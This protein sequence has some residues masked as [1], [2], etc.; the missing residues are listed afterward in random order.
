MTMTRGISDGADAIGCAPLPSAGSPLHTPRRRG[1]PATPSCTAAA[2][3]DHHGQLLR[4]ASL[5]ADQ[6]LTALAAG[7][8]TADAVAPF[9]DYLREEILPLTRSEDRLLR[10]DSDV[11]RRFLQDHR[12]LR[13]GEHVLTAAAHSANPDSQLIAGTIRGILDQL[14]RHVQQEDGCLLGPNGPQTPVLNRPATWYP[15]TEGPDVDLDLL[16]QADMMPAML[17]RLRRLRP[18]ETLTLTAHRPLLALRVGVSRID[19]HAERY[20]WTVIEDGPP[21]WRWLLR[22]VARSDC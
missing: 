19:P 12:R 16:P 5:H 21:T 20:R 13:E 18:G 1:E 9:L 3:V 15:L 10:V 2:L 8:P 7:A 17:R 4:Q 6:S 14:E 11:H 22:R